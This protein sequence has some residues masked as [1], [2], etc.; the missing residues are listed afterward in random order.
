VEFLP[1]DASLKKIGFKPSLG[2]TS[3]SGLAVSTDSIPYREGGYNTTVHQIPGQTQ[4]QPITAQRGVLLGTPQHWLWMKR[5]FSLTGNAQTSGDFR[6]DLNIYVL[7]H[8]STATNQQ[9]QGAYASDPTATIADR[10]A[11]KFHVV[12]AWPTAVAYSDLNAGDNA[13]LVE[14]ITL[15]HEGFDADFAKSY[16]DD[17][18]TSF[19]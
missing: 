19:N 16:T 17:V 18:K 9:D 11:A 15:V 10:V 4:F 2:F 6:A 13:I 5:L 1:H 8:P 14:Q 12:N 3:L 7:A